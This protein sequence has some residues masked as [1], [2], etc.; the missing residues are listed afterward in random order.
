MSVT[1]PDDVV[2]GTGGR[3]VLPRDVVA[4]GHEVHHESELV[5]V[6]GRGGERV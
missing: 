3:I 6:M 2:D 1:L 4:Q 5:V